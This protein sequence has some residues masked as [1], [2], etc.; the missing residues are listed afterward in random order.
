MEFC[1][2]HGFEHLVLEATIQANE[3]LEEKVPA[4]VAP[5][6]IDAM[7]RK[8]KSEAVRVMPEPQ[9]SF[10]FDSMVLA[11]VNGVYANG[12]H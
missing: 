5:D 9:P 1:N 3:H 2:Q 11:G 12:K 8:I 10:R 6:E 7:L 4:V